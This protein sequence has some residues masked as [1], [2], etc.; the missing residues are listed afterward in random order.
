MLDPEQTI[1]IS[2]VGSDNI[3]E[4]VP[5]IFAIDDLK[6]ARELGICGVLTGTL[7][8]APQQ[9]LFLSIPLRLMLEEAL[10]LLLNGNAIAVSP[11]S[12][13]FN[14]S[15]MKIQ[16]ATTSMIEI[17]TESE[18]LNF[19]DEIATRSALQWAQEHASDPSYLLYKELRQIGYFL[20]PGARFGGK[21]IAYPGDPLRYHSHLTV[22]NPIDYYKDPVDVLELIGNAR[23]GTTVKKLWV[24]G[25]IRDYH[26]DSEKKEITFYS[27]EWAGFG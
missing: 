21:F 7:P 16:G 14:K 15:S 8:S 6:K 23:L 24:I 20:S 27:I 10:W 12:V 1:Q 9:N 22:H 18:H 26:A 13:N 25:G 19:E 11:G 17:P 5:F 3:W 4:A 2:F